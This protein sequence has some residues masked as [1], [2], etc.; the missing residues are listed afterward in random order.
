MGKFTALQQS[1]GQ[2]SKLKFSV[3][4]R[5]RE[6]DFRHG[7]GR[8]F[9]EEAWGVFAGEFEDKTVFVVAGEAAFESGV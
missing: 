7:V 3:D 2:P 5:V 9:Y 1:V 4:L 6:R 8:P